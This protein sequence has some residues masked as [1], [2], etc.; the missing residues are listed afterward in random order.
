MGFPADLSTDLADLWAGLIAHGAVERPTLWLLFFD[1]GEVVFWPPIMIDGLPERP[2][3]DGVAGL[4]HLVA[5]QLDSG[6]ADSV[7]LLVERPGPV[8]MSDSDRGWAQALW[9]G[10]GADLVRWPIY[11]ASEVALQLFAP[12][13]L[14]G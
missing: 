3:P 12:D 4:A 14:I 9:H 8:A 10:L 11:Y 7:A 1:R 6:L 5:H 2:E 13:D